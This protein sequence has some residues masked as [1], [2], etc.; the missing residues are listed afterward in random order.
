MVGAFG[1]YSRTL[2]R[3][4]GDRVKHWITLNEPW[5]MSNYYAMGA[6]PARRKGPAT[7]VYTA[8]HN[9]LLAHAEAV[10]IYR[11]EFHGLTDGQIGITLNADWIEP[12]KAGDADDEA[13]AQRF[14]D[15]QLGWFADPIY[16]GD[17]PASMR[18]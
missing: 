8:S 12:R 15:F 17:Y 6:W 2:F 3:L 5:C 1:N 16:F 9:Q 4:Y 14:R 11:E 13:A 7:D 10:R 18:Q